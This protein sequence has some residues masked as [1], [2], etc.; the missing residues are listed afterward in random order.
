ME[1]LKLL[2]YEED[3]DFVGR[4]FGLRA[5]KIGLSIPS[6]SLYVGVIYMSV[7]QK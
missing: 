6:Y 7:Y 2:M 4:E 1:E 3:L 5:L